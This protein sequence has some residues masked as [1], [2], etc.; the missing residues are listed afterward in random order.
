[1]ENQQRKM[2]TAYALMQSAY[3]M[4]YCMV[5]TFAAVFLQARGYS[6]TEI[7]VIMAAQRAGAGAAAAYS[8]AC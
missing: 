3:W 8:R 1:M 7:G 6:G 2:N 4:A 5:L